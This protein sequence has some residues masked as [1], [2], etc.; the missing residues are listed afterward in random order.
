M[1]FRVLIIGCGAIAGGYDAERPDT[2]WPLSHA[3]AIARSDEF[4]LAACVDPDDTVREAFAKR[5]SVPHTA[6]S[7]EEL[8]A[9]A[10][11]FDL[12]VIASPT[13]FHAEQLEWALEMGPKA[14]FCEKPAANDAE[15]AFRLHHVYRQRKIPL[16]VNYTRRWQPGLRPL[17]A[18]ISGDEWGEL[19][20]AVGTYGKGIMHNGS[21]MID[22]LQMFVGPMTV[23]NAGPHCFDHWDNDPS[24][25]AILTANDIGQPVHL[26][27]GDSGSFTQFELVLT[28]QAGEIAL[29]DGALRIE[30][31]RVQDSETFAGYRT[32]GP[33][34]SEAGRYEE[35]M[36]HAYANLA[37][38]IARKG[39]PQHDTGN[40]SLDLCEQIRTLALK[41]PMKDPR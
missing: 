40:S 24:V 5:W 34:Q 37:Q 4:E 3:G 12:I 29:R 2:E 20:S 22:L 28:Y 13:R 23:Q 36:A 18:Q 11:A 21:H 41:T 38:V 10:G 6:A 14:V 8:K 32:L 1:A 35:A 19:I 25:S 27:A 17:L 39:Y 15:T 16:I 31:R 30:T 33:V 7:L 9:S 26:V